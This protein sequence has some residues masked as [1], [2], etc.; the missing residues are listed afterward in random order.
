M[1][2]DVVEVEPRG[3]YRLWLRFLTPEIPPLRN[4]AMLLTFIQTISSFSGLERF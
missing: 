3:K 2:N 4:L 1:L